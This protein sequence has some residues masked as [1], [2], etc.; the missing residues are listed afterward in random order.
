MKTYECVIAPIGAPS[1][2]EVVIVLAKDLAEALVENCNQ[3][4]GT[5]VKT[6]VEI[7]S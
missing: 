4:P 1:Q 6:I 3:R 5:Y 2:E 7:S